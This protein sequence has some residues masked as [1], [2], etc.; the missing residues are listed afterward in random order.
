[1]GKLKTIAICTGI[2]ALVG[3]GAGGL[4]RGALELIDYSSRYGDCMH[5]REHFGLSFD[6]VDLYKCPDNIKLE[7]SPM[8]FGQDYELD[9]TNNDGFVDEIA[10]GTKIYARQ[11]GPAELFS[12]ADA[13]FKEY[14]GK[15]DGNPGAWRDAF[16]W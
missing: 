15:F 5:V 11:E 3:I 1:M 13:K 2:G 14:L 7:I 16:S 8:M 9:D 12:N 4:C 6:Q 10:L